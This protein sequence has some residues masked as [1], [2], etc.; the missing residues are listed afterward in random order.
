MTT[1]QFYENSGPLIK[2]HLSKLDQ[3][4]YEAEAGKLIGRFFQ[5]KIILETHLE[6][7]RATYVKEFDAI[8]WD[9]YWKHFKSLFNDK[10]RVQEFINL[11]SFWF[12][13]SLQV[14]SDTPYLGQSFFLKLPVFI[15]EIRKDK[16]FDRI[17]HTMDNQAS[18]FGWYPL[19]QQILIE[20]SKRKLLGL[21]PR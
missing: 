3:K 4:S 14:F 15:D 16:G 17:I 20:K 13:D 19:L 18:K 12:D 10:A 5:R 9:L 21:L 2:Q 8:F 7:L 6:L 1:G 11:L